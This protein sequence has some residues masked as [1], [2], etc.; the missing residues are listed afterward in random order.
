M[1]TD[2]LNNLFVKYKHLTEGL[3]HNTLWQ[4]IINETLVTQNG[5]RSFPTHA[6]IFILGQSK[7]KINVGIAELNVSGYIPTTFSIKA[8]TPKE[9]IDKMIDELN[10][11]IFGITPERA[12]E[13]QLSSYR[14]QNA[15]TTVS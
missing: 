10:L 4:I 11:E 6:F 7:D 2:K 9:E 14:K 13:I 8:D 5:K 15:E 3:F 12:F 1:K